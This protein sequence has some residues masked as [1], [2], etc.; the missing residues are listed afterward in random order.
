M[1]DIKITEYK[2]PVD[3]GELY[4]KKWNPTIVTSD[5]PIILLHDSLGCVGLWRGLPLMLAEKLSRTVIA[6]D[7]LG[8]GKSSVCESLPSIDFI[9]EEASQIF[10]LVKKSLSIKSYITLGHSVGGAMAINIAANDADCIGVISISAQ[11]FVE[12]RTLKGIKDA[13]EAFKQKGQIERLQKWHS[14]KAN[15]VLSAWTETWLLPEFSS[16]SLKSCIGNVTCPVLAIHGD[17]DEY[18]STAFPEFIVNNT[19]G[20]STLLIVKDCGHMPHKEKTDDV[21]M[22]IHHFINNSVI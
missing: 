3:E 16:W 1:S 11:A 4:V 18:G 6:Y 9:E 12:P 20:D 8:A 2:V 19:V 15:W 17:N 21:V 13:K 14:D 7:R 10:P 5:V 22:A